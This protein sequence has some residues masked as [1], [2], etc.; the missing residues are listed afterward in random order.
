MVQ[1]LGYLPHV[2]LELGVGA[3][4]GTREDLLP[5]VRIE[6]RLRCDLPSHL[7]PGDEG[8][9]VGVRRQVVAGDAH[10]G[11]WVGR[12]QPDRAPALHGD[13]RGPHREGV[14]F[15]GLEPVLDEV[16]GTEVELD[17][18][19]VEA[20]PS[21]HEAAPLTDVGAEHPTPERHVLEQRLGFLG[22]GE[23]DGF[24]AVVD[25]HDD[26]VVLEVVTHGEIHDRF[27]AEAAQLV[28]RSDARQHQELW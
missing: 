1:K 17:V 8:A 18:G 27:D 15:V 16:G 20:I 13:E 21:V 11:E 9:H 22:E 7:H 4:A 3:V 19:G 2:V 14:P 5:A 12:R 23:A 24:G 10:L 25:H 26:G 6:R 28:G